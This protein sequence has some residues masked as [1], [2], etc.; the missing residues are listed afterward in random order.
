MAMTYRA[1][2]QSG[3]GDSGGVDVDRQGH[4]GKT[5]TRDADD[6]ALHRAGMSAS[7]ASRERRSARNDSVRGLR[8][9]AGGDRNEFGDAQALQLVLR[10]AGPEICGK[11][12]KR[13][14]QGYR[15]CDAHFVRGER[16]NGRMAVLDAGVREAGAREVPVRP[17]LQPR[18]VQA[19]PVLQPR[20]VQAER[21]RACELKS[22]RQGRRRY[23][24]RGGEGMKF[25]L[26]YAR[27]IAE[28]IVQRL[29]P[30]SER[31]EI[32][33]SIRRTRPQVGDIDLVAIPR[34]ESG[35]TLFGDGAVSLRST[36]FHRALR[37]IAP[38]KM[39]GEKILRFEW[40]SSSRDADTASVTK[41]G[42]DIYIA[43]P[44][45][46]ATLLV[47]R[48]GSEQHN[49]Y[50]AERARK[51]GGKLHADGAG[52]ELPGAYDEVAQTAGPVRRFAIATED[53]LFTLLF[54]AGAK[55]TAPQPAE[56]E[57]VN[58][59]PVWLGGE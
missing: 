35:E 8:A 7:R 43:T 3:N 34:F 9:A 31:I 44:E 22:C 45:S 12:T 24:R 13:R 28:D 46:W 27:T 20:M 19:E 14:R 36:E 59:R 16:K 32:A 18:M 40:P 54:G 25:P 11:P 5:K 17:V 30:H 58:D 56:R 42:V 41:I 37:Q 15:R 52:L 53:E 21:Q 55:V 29:A 50:L 23:E 33:G 26:V 47:I 48:T 51:L 49:I 39:D 1:A 38:L 4:G 6:P 2:N 10:A 57:I